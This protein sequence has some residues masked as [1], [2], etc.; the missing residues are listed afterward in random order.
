MFVYSYKG[1]E[2]GSLEEYNGDL[3]ARNVKTF[4]Q[5]HLPRFSKRISLNHIDLSSSNV[6]RYPRVMLLSTKK[7]TPLIW[8]V[9][10]GLYHKRFT[11][12]DAEV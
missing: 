11:F 2:K 10:S 12:Y 6:E 8:R 7:D 9:L 3:T 4:C 1:S 5:D